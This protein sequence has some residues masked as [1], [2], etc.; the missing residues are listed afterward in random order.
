LLPKYRGAAPIQRAIL[1]D[2]PETGVTI[3][4]MDA[5]LD[6]GQILI[7]EKTLIHAEDDSETLHDRLA[8]L[9]AKLL[10]GAIGEYSAGRLAPQAQPAEGVSYASKIKKEDGR[11]DWTRSAR[12]IWNLVRGMRP[13]PG[14]FTTLPGNPPAVLKIWQ[15]QT[16]EANGSPGNLLQADKGGLVVACGAGSVRLVTLQREGG[17]RLTAQQ[18]LA[19]HPLKVGT[20]LGL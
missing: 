20:K 15:A 12:V 17:R 19:G 10:I 7:Q 4:K 1:D 16:E 5:G 6:T 18:F 2:E 8:R 9:G 11:V 13:W 3:M 14:A